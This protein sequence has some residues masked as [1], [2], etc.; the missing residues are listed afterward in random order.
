MSTEN[1]VKR[2]RGRPRKPVQ[3]EAAPP[4]ARPAHR[5]PLPFC[6]DPARFS[7]TL[8]L[9]LQVRGVKATRARELAA[10]VFGEKS[11][12]AFV[13]KSA[14]D[15]SERGMARDLKKK[16]GAFLRFELRPDLDADE[17]R[18]APDLES[19]TKKMRRKVDALRLD[20]EG[21]AWVVNAAMWIFALRSP[22][23]RI[24][25][26]ARLHLIYQGFPAGAVDLI[27]D[28]FS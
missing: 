16:D 9:A 22:D 26:G 4:P 14:W 28:I 13:P 5:P 25:A 23:P 6:D 1:I 8:A 2:V 11:S 21:A 17:R 20:A 15:A 19:A 18:V 10:I 3:V 27:A 24:K 7:V 12:I